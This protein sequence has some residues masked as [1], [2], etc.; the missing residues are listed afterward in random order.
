[1]RTERAKNTKE[2]G[3]ILLHVMVMG[4]LMALIAAT[5]LRTTL[6]RS[7]AAA[8]STNILQEKR[9]DHAALA[10]VTAAWNADRTIQDICS[11][12]PPGW[13]G[14]VNAAVSPNNCNCTCTRP[15]GPGVDAVTV[16]ASLVG[17]ACQLSIASA[18]LP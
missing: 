5:L 14:C 4:I 7:Q 6:L 3:S 2:R 16:T 1:M 9:D 13:L 10:A 15:A 18:D 17:G 11:A 8:R 12:A